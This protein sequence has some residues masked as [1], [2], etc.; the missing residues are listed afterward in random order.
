MQKQWQNSLFINLTKD[1][2]I[3]FTPGTTVPPK[4]YIPELWNSD[5]LFS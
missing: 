3:R 5:T 4:D 1:F 2:N